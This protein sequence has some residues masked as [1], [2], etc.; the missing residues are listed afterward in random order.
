MVGRL[1]MIFTGIKHHWNPNGWAIQTFT[2][3]LALA[4]FRGKGHGCFGG[5]GGMGAYHIPQLML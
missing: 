2:A 1:D 4:L 5:G 3:M